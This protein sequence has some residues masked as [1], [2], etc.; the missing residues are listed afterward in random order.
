[1]V[2]ACLALIGL[3]LVLVSKNNGNMGNLTVKSSAFKDGDMIPQRFTC[4]GENINP[5]LEIKN[6]PQG[7]K[8]LALIMDDPDATGG[9]IWDHW[10]LWNI[11]PKTQYITEDSVPGGAT[12]GLNSWNKNKY[13]GPCP[14]E[15]SKPHR[16]IFN[17]YALDVLLDIPASSTKADLAQAMEG[18]T[19]EKTTLMG[20]YGR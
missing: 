16:Y 10:I 17:V 5:L 7:A 1:M 3:I 4:D 6:V 13:G 18:H 2:F 12:E 8:S 11:D 9:R 14:P 19:I 20:L 15:G